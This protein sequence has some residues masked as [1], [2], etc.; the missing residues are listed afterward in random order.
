MAVAG[1]LAHARYHGL[2]PTII[3]EPERGAVFVEPAYVAFGPRDP[4]NE[5]RSQT[6]R[7]DVAAPII[8]SSRHFAERRYG[9]VLP[10]GCSEWERVKVESAAGS[11]KSLAIPCR[12]RSAQSI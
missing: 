7:T 3:A 4:N 9:Y 8:G 1:R 6:A 5:I 10:V 2:L 12:K 11:G